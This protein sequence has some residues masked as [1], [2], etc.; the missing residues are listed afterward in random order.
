MKLDYNQIRP[1][2]FEVTCP[3]NP[4]IKFWSSSTKTPRHLLQAVL[5]HKDARLS[6]K[7]LA[8]LDEKLTE[9]EAIYQERYGDLHDEDED[10]KLAHREASR[11]GGG[12]EYVF[13]I[14]RGKPGD[15][16]LSE[17]GSHEEES[18]YKEA[19][20]DDYNVIEYGIPQ[21]GK[22]GDDFMKLLGNRG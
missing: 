3:S 1:G 12:L 18:R 4:N 15:K 10:E 7:E 14:N 8:E 5:S 13:G 17:L 2:C 21:S 19:M 6:P 22:N 16:F 11:N 9:L 20:R